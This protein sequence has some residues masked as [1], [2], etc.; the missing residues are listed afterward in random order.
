MLLRLSIRAYGLAGKSLTML[1]PLGVKQRATV[2]YLATATQTAVAKSNYNPLHATMP[3]NHGATP[4]D[5]ETFDLPKQVTGTAA[6]FT[7]SK[8][9][10]A[11]FRRDG[12]FQI[13]LTPAQSTALSRANAFAKSFFEEPFAVKLKHVDD[14]SFAGYV[15]SGEELTDGIADYPEIFTV[16]KDLPRNDFRVQLRWPCHGPCPWPSDAYA[17]AMQEYMT[18]LGSSGE[19]LLQ[20]LTLGLGLAD[21]HALT[22]LTKDGWHHMRVLQFPAAD[23]TNGKGKSGRG[24]GSHTDYGLLVL[25]A[26]DEVGGLFIRRPIR[27]ENWRNWEKSVAG[28]K[29]GDDEWSYIPPEPNVMTVMAGDML[30]YLT[31]S[32][33]QS[34]PHKVGLNTRPRSVFAYFHEPN[35]SA[36]MKPLPE[37]AAAGDGNTTD[38]PGIHY[39]THFANMCMR[40]YPERITAK[41]VRVENRMEILPSTVMEDL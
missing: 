10:I 6:D 16:I 12:I 30:Q 7:L 36:L 39:G 38:S 3:P 19:K 37:Y 8:S 5:L 33:I 31:S 17:A 40:N 22:R 28:Y 21:P 1:K 9:M 23:Q 32:F 25:S 20:L 41:R 15:A 14:Q 4:V 26:Q 18:L 29:E 34:T 24:I 2:R 13:K 11:A 35:F 27:G